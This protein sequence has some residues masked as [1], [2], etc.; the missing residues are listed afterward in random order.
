ML[1]ELSSK[2]ADWS[3]LDT[4]IVLSAALAGMACAIPGNYLLLR[5]Q[6][7]MGD[8]LSHTSLLGIVLAFLFSGWIFTH[9]GPNQSA[10]QTAEAVHWLMFA[11]AIFVGILAAVL[12]EA[13][14]K[15]GRVEATAALG[16]VFT[17]MFAMGLLL[18]RLV[19][20]AHVD[21]D[22]V[23][24]GSL[25]DMVLNTIQIGGRDIPRAVVL[26]GS[27]VLINLCLVTIFFKELQ[28]STFD[29]ELAT[30][31]G[32]NPV[33]INYV[34]MAL[35]ACTIVAV[36]E[37]VGSIL[38]IAML[39][40]PTATAFLL[41][42][43]LEWMI[44]LSLFIASL[45]AVL[46]HAMAISLPSII[47]SRL[48]FE[49]VRDASTTGMMGATSGALFFLALFFAPRH[50]ILSRQLQ[51][52]LLNLRVAGDDLLGLLYRM[53]E[54]EL[55]AETRQ[56][57]LLLSQ[58][59]GYRKFIPRLALWRLIFQNKVTKTNSGYHLTEQGKERA[60]GLV[61]AHRLWESYMA[62]HFDLSDERLHKSAHR[63]EHY[64]DP[65]LRH[66][67]ATELESPTEDPHGR[68][69]PEEHGSRRESP[70]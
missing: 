32:I 1:S 3:S 54:F 26:N 63:I 33:L 43:R 53:E 30:A 52:T 7:M 38:V 50:G 19:D 44:P 12:S 60:Q 2:I 34:L 6:S 65:D 5:R 56:A 47:F 51:K 68:T 48:G 15:L 17:T 55:A 24:Y 10:A 62:Q 16:V 36:F 41:T 67:L 27:M 4:W 21:V 31:L 49:N 39:V 59:L 46:G 42:S 28:I 57:P 35:T 18:M 13:I 45:S 66:D 9:E 20:K 14:Q 70:E 69:I 64:L 61:R 29:S 58:Q 25:F 37:S 11:G 40:V 23:L 22:C 8:A